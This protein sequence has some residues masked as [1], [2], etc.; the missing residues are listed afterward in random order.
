MKCKKYGYIS[1]KIYDIIDHDW[2]FVC[3]FCLSMTQSHLFNGN[4]WLHGVIGERNTGYA[5]N[6]IIFVVRNQSHSPTTFEREEIGSVNGV[7]GDS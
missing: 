3:P 2:Y 1:K 5:H 4:D 6:K 7:T